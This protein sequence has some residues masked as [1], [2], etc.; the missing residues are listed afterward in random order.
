MR[1]NTTPRP[2]TRPTHRRPLVWTAGSLTVAVSLLLQ[3]CGS[4]SDSGS[5]DGRTKLTFLNQSRGQEAA[6]NQLAKQYTKKTG[7]A[8]TVDSPGPSD[9][10]AKLQAKAQSRSMPDVYSSFDAVDMAPFYKAG[11][12]MDL[13]P[14]L[15]GAWGDEFAPGVIKMST[16][17]KDN[18]LGVP[19]GVYSVHWETQAYG[20]IIDP[21]ATG[22][23]PKTPPKTMDDLI[24][25][26]KASNKDGKGNFLVAASLTPN[27]IPAFASNW[28]TDE[29]ISATYAGKESWK[30]DGW[31]KAFQLL[32]DMKKAGVI[33]NGSLPGGNG[34]NPAVETSF[35]NK[36]EV[37]AIFDSSAGVSVG[38]RTAPDYT[39]YSSMSV[40]AAADA[41]HP[42]RSTGVPGKGAVVNPRGEHAKEAL[43]FVKWLTE[44]AQQ[45]VFSE[46]A[47]ILPT[48]PELLAGGSIP[49]QLTGFAEASKTRQI[50]PNS[51]T[52]DVYTAIVRGTQSLVLGEKTVDQVLDDLESAQG[53]S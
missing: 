32:V 45:K 33:A 53:R 23:D 8:I 49:S 15:K 47:L 6:L 26:L 44:P 24:A 9:Y 51:V 39:D 48:S 13:Q 1:R 17:T 4:G 34:D 40:P 16:F 18:N 37:G 11:W 7:I 41:K 20:L 5:D 27:L 22:I 10:L 31:R 42:P 52:T 36:H 21:K 46:Q 43:A 50:V 35:F 25:A 19:A 3:G 28:L 12:A 2:A 30:E 29:Q 14:E 38:K